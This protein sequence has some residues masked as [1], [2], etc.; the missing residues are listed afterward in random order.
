M[1]ITCPPGTEP[2]ILESVWNPGALEQGWKMANPI[3][4]RASSTAENLR[5][6]MER[7]RKTPVGDTVKASYQELEALQELFKYSLNPPTNGVYV[8]LYGRR[9]EVEDAS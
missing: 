7:A 3:D 1:L 4:H 6:F 5:M 8:T 9:I 2:P